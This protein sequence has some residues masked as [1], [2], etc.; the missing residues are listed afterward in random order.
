M[1]IQVFLLVLLTVSAE[2]VISQIHVIPNATKQPAWV[3]P[4]KF[5]DADLDTAIIYIGYDED[6]TTPLLVLD[7]IFGEIIQ[8]TIDSAFSICIGDCNSVWLDA[9]V[10]SFLT[11]GAFVL[12]SANFTNPIRVIYDLAALRSDSLPLPS[13]PS[14]PTYKIKLTFYGAVEDCYTNPSDAVEIVLTDSIIDEE[15]CSLTKDTLVINLEGQ[16]I[17]IFRE[18]DDLL[19]TVGI[20]YWDAECEPVL[21]VGH[22]NIIVESCFTEYDY[23]LYDLSGQL[24]HSGRNN[25]KRKCNIKL[26]NITE[27]LYILVL[28]NGQT[29]WSSKIFLH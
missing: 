22:H 15:I 2:F 27:N 11:H 20:N 7:T 16:I 12:N 18:W 24:I 28:Q 1:K 29:L 3:F 10:V 5:I 23:Y 21:S 14:Q 4:I 6:A 25:G 26:N 13:E 8:D 17:V 9:T 19:S